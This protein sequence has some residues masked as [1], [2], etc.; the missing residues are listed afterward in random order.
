MTD[1]KNTS[2]IFF[3]D[4]PYNPMDD[5]VEIIEAGPNAPEG[6]EPEGRQEDIDM[7]YYRLEADKT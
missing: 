2:S 5:A 6:D 7:Y 1:T 3:P 4:N